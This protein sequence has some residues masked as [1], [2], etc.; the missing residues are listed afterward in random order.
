MLFFSRVVLMRVL[1]ADAD[2]LSWKNAYHQE[3]A[4]YEKLSQ[5]IKDT[6]AQFKEA[7]IINRD[8]REA[9]EPLTEVFIPVEPAIDPPPSFL[10]RVRQLGDGINGYLQ[11]AVR[12]AV[13][14]VLAS[15]QAFH[16]ALDLGP[17]GEVMPNNCS[18]EE[19]QGLV[20]KLAPVAVKYV[21]R[22]AEESSQEE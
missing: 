5:L 21:E 19:F 15:V 8:V 9:L 6:D 13:E 14:R 3:K 1:G 4:N 2:A 17:V 18:Q 22:I 12:Q 11:N 10:A 7:L 16:P 20:Q